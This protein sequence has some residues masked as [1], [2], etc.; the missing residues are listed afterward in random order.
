LAAEEADNSMVTPESAQDAKSAILHTLL[1]KVRSVNEITDTDA[2]DS[3]TLIYSDPDSRPDRDG[4]I[5][6]NLT[7][8][9]SVRNLLFLFGRWHFLAATGTGPD[10][11]RLNSKRLEWLKA[12]SLIP[13]RRYSVG[14]MKTLFDT[15]DSPAYLG[16]GTPFESSMI[17]AVWKIFLN[18][19]DDLAITKQDD[20]KVV[21]ESYGSYYKDDMDHIL[22]LIKKW[23]I[24]NIPFLLLNYQE[25]SEAGVISLSDLFS[26]QPTPND[27]SQLERII[28]S[29]LLNSTNLES[30]AMEKVKATCDSY[31]I[32]FVLMAYQN[33]HTTLFQTNKQLNAIMTIASELN[34]TITQNDKNIT[35]QG[36]NFPQLRNYTGGANGVLQLQK[37]ADGDSSGSN[38]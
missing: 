33:Q 34:S 1:Y 30:E 15:M 2:L 32:T 17:L 23:T 21:R 3:G 35:I 13:T 20:K 5:A 27:T 14:D 25:L 10:T 29:K 36:L 22:G 8:T 19:R 28:G 31:F 7:E 11:S 16:L 6:V 9:G 18:L 24:N 37:L 12:V 4:M 26:R 38:N